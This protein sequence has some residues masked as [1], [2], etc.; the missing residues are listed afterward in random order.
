[1]GCLTA[2]AFVLTL[3]KPDRI[4]T[5]RKV[6]AYLGLRPRQDQSGDRNPQLGINKGGDE[7]L[8][9][10]LVQSGHYVLGA[11]GPDCELRRWGLAI[12]GRGGRR[13]KKR[14]AP[15][16]RVLDC[17]APF[18]PLALA[19]GGSGGNTNRPPKIK[20][21]QPYARDLD[22]VAPYQKTYFMANCKI[23]GDPA[24][25]IRPNCA[26]VSVLTGFAKLT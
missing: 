15:H 24:L 20:T 2:L 26:L 23:R 17:C 22:S 1:M 7:F 14:R 5:S 6:G 12:A 9:R 8:R 10:L 25:V 16:R 4:E 11:F 18:W 3:D 21:R 13:A 19:T